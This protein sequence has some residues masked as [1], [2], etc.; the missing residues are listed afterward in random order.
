MI[1]FLCPQEKIF[2]QYFFFCRIEVMSCGQRVSNF[3]TS[4]QCG[5]CTG[6]AAP[7]VPMVAQAMPVATQ[8]GCAAVSSGCGPTFTGCTLAAPQIPSFPCSP[9]PL[10]QNACCGERYFGLNVAYGQ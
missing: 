2:S 7:M 8:G 9:A 5:S 10:V 1:F 3:S 4:A 6:A